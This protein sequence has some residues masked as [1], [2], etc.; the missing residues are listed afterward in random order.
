MKATPGKSKNRKEKRMILSK[1]PEQA[2]TVQNVRRD[3]QAWSL[4]L[5]SGKRKRTNYIEANI[6]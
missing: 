6:K 1:A 3:P 5:C 4:S 2:D